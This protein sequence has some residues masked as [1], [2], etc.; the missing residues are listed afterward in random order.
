MIIRYLLRTAGVLFLIIT[1]PVLF[2]EAAPEEGARAEATR[3]VTHALGTIGV[4]ESVE[5]VI[6][7][8]WDFAEMVLT[9]RLTRLLPL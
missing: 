6:A 7:I 3:T 2:A 1:A 8:D 5:R 4:P 9:M